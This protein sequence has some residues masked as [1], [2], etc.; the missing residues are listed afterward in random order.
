VIGYNVYVIGGATNGQ[1]VIPSSQV[2]QGKKRVVI[3]PKKKK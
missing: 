1:S 3:S 2:V